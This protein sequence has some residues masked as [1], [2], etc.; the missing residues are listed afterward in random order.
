MFAVVS[1]E[2]PLVLVVEDEADLSR[3]LCYSLEANGYAVVVADCGREAL[4][5]SQDFHPDLILLDIMLPDISGF[6]VCRQIRS[7]GGEQPAV[8]ILTARTQE[9]DRVAGF[10][11]GADDYM[12]KPFSV[13]ELMLR[14]DAR[15][16]ARRS[17][18]AQTAR[19]PALPAAPPAPVQAIGSDQHIVVG[20]VEIDCAG[21]RL[22]VSGQE[23]RL[24]AQEMRLLLYLASPPERM[25]TRKELLTEVWGY[26]PEV[27]SRTL[28]THIKRIRDK[29]GHAGNVIQ[30]VRGVGYRL[31]EARRRRSQP[32]SEASGSS[33]SGSAGRK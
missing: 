5:Q 6:E 4:R 26:H 19:L 28:D 21:H 25:R 1:Q 24:S 11:V 13:R 29:L 14:I 9:T 3:S 18:V 10:E 2:K 31:G 12:V 16:R 32:K 17:S 27:S 15:L 20:T 30:T 22:L 7:R 23:V 33:K 8:L